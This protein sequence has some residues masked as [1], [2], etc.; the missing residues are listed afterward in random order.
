MRPRGEIREALSLAADSLWSE[1]RSF[2][3]RDLGE[4]A[5]VGYAAA[6]QTARDMAAAGELVVMGTARVAGVCRP[7]VLYA[8]A[9]PPEEEGVDLASVV[10][11]WADFR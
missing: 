4:V 11:C 6:K 2:T 8:P 5:Q 10:R 1:G 9:D 7:M 3:W